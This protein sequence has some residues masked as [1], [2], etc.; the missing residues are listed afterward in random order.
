MTQPRKIVTSKK[1]GSN[2]SVITYNILSQFRCG[3]RV[4]LW[5]KEQSLPRHS[6]CDLLSRNFLSWFQVRVTPTQPTTLSPSI[7]GFTDQM[8]G[9][10][11]AA[12]RGRGFISEMNQTSLCLLPSPTPLPVSLRTCLPSYHCTF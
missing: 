4:F 6:S 8:T 10:H 5:L 12:E 2:C 11:K 1:N 7:H 3:K 9:S